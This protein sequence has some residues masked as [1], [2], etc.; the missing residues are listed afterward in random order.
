MKTATVKQV[1]VYKSL[2]NGGQR[3]RILVVQLWNGLRNSYPEHRCSFQKGGL[4]KLSLQIG[5]VVT[6]LKRKFD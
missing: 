2:C 4:L 1:P 3:E 5:S 6:T